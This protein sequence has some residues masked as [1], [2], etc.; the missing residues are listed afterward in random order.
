MTAAPTS[1]VQ[2]TAPVAASRATTVPAGAHV[3]LRLAGPDD[4]HRGRGPTAADHVAQ[5]NYGASGGPQVEVPPDT[6]N[7]R[8]ATSLVKVGASATPK[9]DWYTRRPP[10]VTPNGVSEDCPPRST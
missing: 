9:P 7:A 3:D 5:P 6:G 1:A 10:S 2:R 8:T 4:W